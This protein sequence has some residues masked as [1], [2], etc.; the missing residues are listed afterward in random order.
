MGKTL[1]SGTT[2]TVS[3]LLR[4][5]FDN[6]NLKKNLESNTS[7]AAKGAPKNLKLQ[8]KKKPYR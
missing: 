5:L 7:L 6:K 8:L 1:A 4:A 3:E 2:R